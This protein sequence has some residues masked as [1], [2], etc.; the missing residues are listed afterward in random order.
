ME[1]NDVGPVIATRELEISTS[2]RKV[3]VRLG[4]PTRFP[5][6]NDY[7]C[8]YQVLGLGRDRVFYG[9]GVDS[10]QALILALHN[11]GAELYTS[12]EA[13]TGQLT[14]LDDRNF[15]IPSQTRL[16][17]WCLSAAIRRARQGD[18]GLMVIGGRNDFLPSAGNAACR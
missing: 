12:N 1:L 5:D 18:Y 2:K 13:K 16:P 7:Y 10:L 15:G 4:T 9:A 17:T 14:W 6:G 8:P 3:T 11:I